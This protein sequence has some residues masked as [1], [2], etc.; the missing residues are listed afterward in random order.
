[1]GMCMTRSPATHSVETVSGTG[2][3]RRRDGGRLCLPGGRSGARAVQAVQASR[4][5]ETASVST[6]SAETQLFERA[7]S[8]LRG[9]RALREASNESARTM[10]HLGNGQRRIV[11]GE[12]AAAGLVLHDDVKCPF[13]FSSGVFA[14][15]MLP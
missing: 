13:A 5:P 9:R 10:E 7:H 6:S 2:R 3:G 11:I 1:M 4:P 15:S 14:N 12:V 8:G